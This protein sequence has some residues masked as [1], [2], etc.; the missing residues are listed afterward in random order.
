MLFPF[1]DE[2]SKGQGGELPSSIVCFHPSDLG[3][4]DTLKAMWIIRSKHVAVN[5]PQIRG[6]GSSQPL[7]SL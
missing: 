2:E 7:E 3:D 6:Q 1:A 5:I 4:V